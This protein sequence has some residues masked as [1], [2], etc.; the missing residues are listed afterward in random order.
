MTADEQRYSET[1]AHM[2]MMASVLVESA[3]SIAFCRQTIARAHS[4]A[5]IIDP[6]GYRN[7]MRNLDDAEALLR[8]LALCA[9]SLAPFIDA[10]KARKSE[11]ES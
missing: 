5:P 4:V 8:P 1:M 9:A 7:G 6:T 11:G 10:I 3:G 2:A